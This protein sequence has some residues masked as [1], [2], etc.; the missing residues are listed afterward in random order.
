MNKLIKKYIQWRVNDLDRIV[1]DEWGLEQR[2]YDSFMLMPDILMLDLIINL[3][4]ADNSD[5]KSA[6]P[7]KNA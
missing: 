3:V 6:P 2:W 5:F 1:N 4:T 7:I